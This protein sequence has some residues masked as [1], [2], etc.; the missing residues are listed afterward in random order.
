MLR[1]HIVQHRPHR[2]DRR[3]LV[4]RH[5]SR[6]VVLAQSPVRRQR[7]R[8]RIVEGRVAGHGAGQ[9]RGK[10]VASHVECEPARDHAI[11]QQP[12]NGFVGD[13]IEDPLDK[14]QQIGLL[15]GR[16]SLGGQVGFLLDDVTEQGELERPPTGLAHDLASEFLVVDPTA[17][18]VR[19]G[20]RVRERSHLVDERVGKRR[21]EPFGAGRQ[22][23][24]AGEDQANPGMRLQERVKERPEL[25]D[26][27]LDRED[28]LLSRIEDEDYRPVGGALAE[29]GVEALEHVGLR[30]LAN[31]LKVDGALRW[32]AQA[33]AA[34][35]ERPILAVVGRQP[36][37]RGPGELI[38]EL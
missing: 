38:V 22:V 35:E 12:A 13:A 25:R 15:V 6:G 37:E 33:A 20:L 8:S 26:V 16:D 5:A 3:L 4:R 24:A 1:R 2:L 29:A 31:D 21:C 10:D 9:V 36:L 32:P 19:L 17:A 11:A 23:V 27:T 28:E 30:P 34:T 18:Q 7:I 14:E